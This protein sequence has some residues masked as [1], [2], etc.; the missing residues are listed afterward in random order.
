MSDLVVAWA[1]IQQLIIMTA[2]VHELAVAAGVHEL[3]VAAGIQQ[4]G[5]HQV[6]A[7]FSPEHLSLHMQD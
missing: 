4:L 7:V 1:G 5:V 2:W 3:A 6:P